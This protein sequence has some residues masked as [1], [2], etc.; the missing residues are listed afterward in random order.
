LVAFAL[1]YD[2]IRRVSSVENQGVLRMAT[3]PRVASRACAAWVHEFLA[4]HSVTAGFTGLPGSSF[5]VHGARIF[6]MIATRSSM[7]VC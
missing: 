4:D 6:A 2:E 1:T 3:P 7:I 5:T